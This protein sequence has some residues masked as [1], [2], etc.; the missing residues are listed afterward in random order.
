MFD[1][2][3]RHT[4]VTHLQPARLDGYDYILAGNGLFKRGRNRHVEVM[5]PVTGCR[6][7]GLPAAVPYL[8]LAGERLPGR[9][10]H[11]LLVDARRRAW[12]H[13]AE[14][15]YLIYRDGDRTRLCYPPQEA[16]A[17]HIAYEGSGDPAIIAEIHSHC[18]L[19]AFFSSTDNR[20]ELGFR[21]YGVVGHIFSRPA[22]I[23]RLGLHGDHWPVAVTDLFT[24]SG[25]FN[26]HYRRE[27]DYGHP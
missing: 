2:L 3:V 21:F 25:P 18:E 6:V 10:L 26:L 5:L 23:L 12:A 13:P 14:A 11:T 16:T 1:D 27:G 9:L 22:L 8:R 24:D 7:A 4:T 20:D 15:L 19:G 17:A